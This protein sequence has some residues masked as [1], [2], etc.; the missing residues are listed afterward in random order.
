MS[1]QDHPKQFLNL[2]G[3]R[4][5]ISDTVTRLGAIENLGTPLVICNLAHRF[6]VAQHLLDAGHWPCDVIL[7]PFGR[8]TAAAIAMAALHARFDGD[9]PLLLIM[10]ADH[11]VNDCIAF[12]QAVLDTAELAQ[13]GALV[14]FGIVPDGAETG[15]GYIRAGAARG[16]SRARQIE[17]F[18]EKP[19]RATAQRY[20]DSG[21]YFW[22]SGIFFI[23]ASAIL[24]EMEALA[25]DIMVASERSYL[26][27][28]NGGHF[29]QLDEPT[30][31]ECRAESFDYAV[32]ERTRN[33]VVRPVS[34]GWSDVGSWESLWQVRPKDEDGNAVSGDALL[35]DCKRSYVHG[36]ERLMATLG[37]EDLVIVDTESAVLVAHRS[38]AQDVKKL[39]E[40]AALLESP[41]RDRNRTV[42][43]PWGTYRSIDAQ[44]RFQVKRISVNPGAKLSLQM[45]HHRAEHWVVV[46]GTARVTIDDRVFLLSENESAYIP[47]GARHR[48]ENP[49]RS[50]LE[51]IEVQS[52][53]YLGEDDIVR[54]DDDYGRATS[55]ALQSGTG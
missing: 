1:H 20:V 28:Q 35:M 37:V 13:D 6:L 31:G 54:F 14:T 46:R 36:G 44:E 3:D 4:S 19:D 15:Y 2:L 40:R 38:R 11:V 43:R 25:P 10:P 18:V 39:A 21:N 22:N 51:I 30:F 48:L 27:A 12:R 23:R 49:G 47:V 53:S 16:S 29:I 50:Q 9:D 17:A 52:G 7:E 5:L 45:H 34:M 55:P 33:A 32:M 41:R 8:N 26:A 24:R 42:H